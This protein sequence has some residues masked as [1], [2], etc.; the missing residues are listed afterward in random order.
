M[1]HIP[2][3][4]QVPAAILTRSGGMECRAAATIC[5]RC[6]Q[7]SSRRTA[8]GSCNLHANVTE[9]RCQHNDRSTFGF[10]GA[11]QPTECMRMGPGLW[12]LEYAHTMCAQLT[13]THSVQC[14]SNPGIRGQIWQCPKRRRFLLYSQPK[15]TD[16]IGSHVITHRF[17]GGPNRRGHKCPGHS[18]HKSRGK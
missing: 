13:A 14:K 9:N 1:P 7:H 12:S 15:A 6:R 10:S 11:S 17:S 16:C 18:K 8:D 3:Y 5:Q 2:R 4:F